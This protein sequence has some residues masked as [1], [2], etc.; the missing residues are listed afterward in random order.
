M[1][2]NEAE[3]RTGIFGRAFSGLYNKLRGH[4]S[5]EFVQSIHGHCDEKMYWQRV[6]IESQT[7]V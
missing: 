4:R 6:H 2:R 3:R 5:T 1:F 7:H